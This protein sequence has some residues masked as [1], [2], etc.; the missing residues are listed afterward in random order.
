MQKFQWH[1]T[2][3]C[4]GGICLSEGSQVTNCMVPIELTMWYH[5]PQDYDIGTAA[6]L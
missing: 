4:Y 3:Q 6:S 1:V 5:I 2:N